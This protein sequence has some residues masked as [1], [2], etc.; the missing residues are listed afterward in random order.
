MTCLRLWSC[1]LMILMLAVS[2]VAAQATHAGEEAPSPRDF[3]EAIVKNYDPANPPKIDDL[4][5]IQ[6]EIEGMPAEGVSQALPS[7]FAA[8]SHRDDN[9]KT[10]AVA[11]LFSIALRTGSAA[12]LEDHISSISALLALPSARL[13]GSAVHILTMQR[14]RPG[15]EVV[16]PLLGFLRKTDRDPI[17][18]ADALSALLQIAPENAD[19]L[20]E[21][22]HFLSRRLDV[23]A[24]EAALNAIANS[25]TENAG[26]ADAVI[27]AL[28]DRNQ[29]VRFVAAQALW[30]MPRDVVVRAQPA[31]QKLIEQ[32]DE[33][34]EVRTAAREAM[35][36]IDRQK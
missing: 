32:P 24:R 14:P 5:R 7:I 6:H 31:L 35:K 15:A 11:A 33:S 18:Q 26:L 8:L 34:E 12:L 17:A 16:P 4:L 20:S 3:F 21:A 29:E 36:V 27:A 13:Q 25:N 10:F 30:R 2:E 9:V 19:V 22:E 1:S 28:S 23:P